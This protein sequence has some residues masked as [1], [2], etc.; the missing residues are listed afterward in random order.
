MNFDWKQQAKC[1]GMK[2]ELFFALNPTK[3]AVAACAA[4]PV[5]EECGT[6]AIHN[7]FYGYWGGMSERARERARRN[8]SIA[9]PKSGTALTVRPSTRQLMEIPHGTPQGYQLERKR[10][11]MTCDAC[12]NAQRN[13]I[14]DHREKK[15][16]YQLAKAGLK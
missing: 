13:K 7:E 2:A 15:K 6:Y 16:M 12:K 10:G 1:K 14:K 4:C 9:R 11:L 3:E 5:L 8:L